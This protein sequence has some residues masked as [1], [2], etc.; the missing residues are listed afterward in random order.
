VG[1]H[2]P[3][4][5]SAFPSDARWDAGA[6]GCGELVFDLFVR[7]N[8]LAPG[9]VLHLIATDTGAIE[10]LPAWCGLSGHALVAAHHPDYWIR[11]KGN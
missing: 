3:P 8:A 7:M 6:L 4:S 9:A 10:D 2:T 1:Q 5:D 11:R